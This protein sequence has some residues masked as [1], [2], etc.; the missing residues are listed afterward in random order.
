MPV[1]VLQHEHTIV[2]F[3]VLVCS[4]FLSATPCLS[5]RAMKRTSDEM[6]SFESNDPS[7]SP[8]APKRATPP[9]RSI[10]I[11]VENLPPQCG[12]VSAAFDMAAQGIVDDL[13]TEIVSKFPIPGSGC[14]RSS[15]D[16][17]KVLSTSNFSRNFPRLIASCLFVS[18][19]RSTQPRVIDLHWSTDL[20]N[21]V[22]CSFFRRKGFVC[23]W[24][25]VAKRT[26]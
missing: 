8:I 3:F 13:K 20:D 11:W 2:F 7:Q 5:Y 9:D 15:F 26:H 17:F 4:S 18:S 23:V 16:Y 10:K 22:S 24:T 25:Y 19:G 14:T 1:L 6:L 21:V 12:C